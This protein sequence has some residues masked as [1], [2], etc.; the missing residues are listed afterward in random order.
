MRRPLR[1]NG[2]IPIW[3]V[4]ITVSFLVDGYLYGT[5]HKGV[6]PLV[7]LEMATGKLMWKTKEVKQ[8]VVI[9]AD[10][11]LYIYEGPKS[12]KINLVKADPAKF[13]CTGQVTLTEGTNKHWAHPV[14]AHGRLY[15]R[16]GD[17]LIA[18]T[19]KAN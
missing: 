14:I 17:S 11:M 16:H 19:I 6:G 2:R 13:E 9:Y 8:G 10:G 18:Y 15:V 7:C 5:G 3:I 12:G 1:R 4:S